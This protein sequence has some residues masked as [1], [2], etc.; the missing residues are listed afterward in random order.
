ML[1]R[2]LAVRSPLQYWPLPW[3]MMEAPPWA[4]RKGMACWLMDWKHGKRDKPTKKIGWSLSPRQCREA[5]DQGVAA[6]PS[7]WQVQEMV[8]NSPWK[9]LLFQTTNSLQAQSR[10]RRKRGSHSPLMDHH[11]HVIDLGGVESHALPVQKSTEL[12]LLWNVW[13]CWMDGQLTSS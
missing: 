4:Q 3:C 1:F 10:S 5:R 6:G 12:V 8:R 13:S 2:A 9:C 11:P 7:A